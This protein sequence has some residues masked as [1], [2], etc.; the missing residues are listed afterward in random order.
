MMTLY[1]MNESTHVII[2]TI[3][4]KVRRYK[5]C[6]AIIIPLRLLTDFLLD[7]HEGNREKAGNIQWRW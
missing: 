7:Y 5:T 4:R 1:D 3:Q 6:G 2:K